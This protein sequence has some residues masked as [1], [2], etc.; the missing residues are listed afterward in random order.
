M[1]NNQKCNILHIFIQHIV[2][3]NVRLTAEDI[4]RAIETCSSM[5][6]LN[7]AGNTLGV[8]AAQEIA[9]ALQSRPTFK[10][11]TFPASY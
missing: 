9:N 1:T 2:T 7:L 6:I 5:E 8:E 4:V 11:G 3:I 10:V